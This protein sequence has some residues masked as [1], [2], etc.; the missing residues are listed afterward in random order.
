[1]GN[2]TKN[3]Y[4]H[5]QSNDIEIN[6]PM[7]IEKILELREQAIRSRMAVDAEIILEEDESEERL[8]GLSEISLAQ[9]NIIFNARLFSTEVAYAKLH[10]AVLAFVVQEGVES[11]AEY[12]IRPANQNEWYY[13]LKGIVESGVTRKGKLNDTD[14]LNQMVNWY[15]GL[16]MQKEGE[17]SKGMIRRIAKSV[18][19]E[20]TYWKN[21]M[22][23]GEVAIRDMWA[24]HK[25]RGYDHAKTMRLHG[26]ADGLRK[27]L[28]TI[29][30]EMG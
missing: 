22:N 3:Y 9:S 27:R 29:K 1:M 20:R 13:I 12:Q 21:D 8:E 5:S 26:V 11:D 25:Q 15:P 16:F 23:N 6:T 4:D 14:F 18:S 24:H 19:N 7:S 28:L 17:D 2:I 30:A 10:D